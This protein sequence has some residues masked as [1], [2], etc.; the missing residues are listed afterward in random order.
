MGKKGCCGSKPR[1]K[2]C[3]E[4]KKSHIAAVDREKCVIFLRQPTATASQPA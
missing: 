4:R 3:P 2:K 1:C